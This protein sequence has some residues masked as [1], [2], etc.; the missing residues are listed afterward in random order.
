MIVREGSH[1]Y[2]NLPSIQSGIFSFHIFPSSFKEAFVNFANALK[3]KV[4]WVYKQQKSLSTKIVLV[5]S[6]FSQ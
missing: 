2:T 5:V 1:L 3:L 4:T 6:F